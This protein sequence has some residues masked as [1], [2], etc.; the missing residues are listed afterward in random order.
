MGRVIGAL[1]F[2][3]AVSMGAAGQAYVAVSEEYPPYEYLDGGKP[4]GM[5]IEILQLAAK[6]A[7]IDIDIRFVP[8]A[9]AEEM[10]KAGTADAIFSLFDTPEREKFLS[11]PSVNLGSEKNVI[12]ANKSYQGSPAALSDLKGMTIGTCVGY[13]YGPVFDADTSVIKDE[14][15]DTE[16]LFR[17]LD[18]GRYQFVVANQVVG[19]YTIAKLGLKNIRTLDIDLGVAPLFIGFSRSSPKGQEFL[20]KLQAAMI[21]LQKSGDLDAIRK[22]YAK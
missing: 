21:A 14:S 9:R 2:T 16:T 5:D 7:G 22:K 19:L 20:A 18:G 12:F 13:S 15:N 17:K 6:K 8:W 1:A 11:F 4:A 3:I 10:V